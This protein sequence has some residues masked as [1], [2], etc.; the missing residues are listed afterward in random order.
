M[1]ELP[2]VIPEELY[3]AELDGPEELAAFQQLMQPQ[4]PAPQPQAEELEYQQHDYNTSVYQQPAY[5]QPAY[6]QPAYQ[7]PAY[8]QPAYQQP[9]YQQSGAVQLPGGPQGAHCGPTAAPP[10]AAAIQRMTH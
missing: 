8:P 2:D 7:Q 9:A 3:A 1:E 5:Q 6:L 10:G 4:L